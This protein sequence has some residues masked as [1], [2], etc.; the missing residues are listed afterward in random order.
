[1]KVS[2]HRFI[3]NGLAYAHA[4]R[5]LRME[6]GEALVWARANWKRFLDRMYSAEA[7]LLRDAYER[8]KYPNG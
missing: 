7:C 3:G 5:K 8:I 2:E 1:M 4:R 6:R